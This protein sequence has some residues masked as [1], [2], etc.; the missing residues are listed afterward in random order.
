MRKT[1][2]FDKEYNYFEVGTKITSTS[3]RR[4]PLEY[5]VIYIVTEMREPIFPEDD[6]IC[7]V[8]GHKFGV[9]TTYFKEVE[10]GE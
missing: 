6:A 8:E 3:E 1:K 9:S 7:F 2:T 10:E 4:C 5:G